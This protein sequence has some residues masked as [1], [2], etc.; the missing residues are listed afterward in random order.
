M[1]IEGLG[2]LEAQRAVN[3]GSPDRA[4]NSG[5]VFTRWEAVKEQLLQRYGRAVPAMELEIF[6][7][8]QQ[9]V[10]RRT[11]VVSED[12][13]FDVLHDYLKVA[14]QWKDHVLHQFILP[15][16]RDRQAP[17]HIFGYL[18]NVDGLPKGDLYLWGEDVRLSEQLQAGDRFQY[19]CSLDL[20]DNSWEMD[21]QVLRCLPP[22]EEPLPVCTSAAGRIPPEGAGSVSGYLKFRRILDNPLSSIYQ[23]MQDLAQDWPPEETAA[24][25]T[26]RIR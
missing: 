6:L 18:G 20:F 25:I 14:L 2:A 3:K 21:L 12:I 13:T 16:A 7:D 9:Y 5:R 24:E 17:L 19:K 1:C 15:P 23:K 4:H 26:E 11:L 8:L 22:T 10:M